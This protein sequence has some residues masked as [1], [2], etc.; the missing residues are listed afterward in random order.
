[1]ALTDLTRDC[2]TTVVIEIVSPVGQ[3]AVDDL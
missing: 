2:L 1:M 3:V